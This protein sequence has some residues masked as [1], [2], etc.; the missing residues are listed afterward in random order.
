[1]D[2]LKAMEPDETTPVFDRAELL[3]RLMADEELVAEILDSFLAE[4]PAQVAA[5]VDAFQRGDAVATE[6]LAHRV[7]GAAANLSAVR[8]QRVA[9]AIEAACRASQLDAAARLVAQLDGEYQRAAAAMRP[10]G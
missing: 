3:D 8:L 4:T 6:R 10:G 1:M 7:K 5:V 9:G 2:D